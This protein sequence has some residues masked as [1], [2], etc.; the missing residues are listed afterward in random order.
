MLRR[1]ALV[2]LVTLGTVVTLGASAFA[3]SAP[4]AL[5]PGFKPVR[6]APPRALITIVAAPSAHRAASMGTPAAPVPS[7]SRSV[8]VKAT[9][10][11][12]ALSV[13]PIAVAP[14]GGALQP[15][16]SGSG[17]TG[18]IGSGFAATP[19][20]TRALLYGGGDVFNNGAALG[21]TWVWNGTTWSPKCG[22]TMP[23]ATVP[24]AP[25]PRDLVS[26]ATGPTGVVLYGG[27]TN[28]GTG[29]TT[30]HGDSY[31]W[32]GTA[33]RQICSS[34]APGARAG[35]AMAGNGMI[36]LL[37]GGGDTAGNGPAVPFG[38]TWRF[39]GN[40]WTELSPGGAGQPAGRL[41][42]SMAWDGH[43]FALFG[44]L[45]PNGS[46]TQ[47]TLADTWIWTGAQWVQACGQPLA[48]CG[49]PPRILG[50]F[51]PLASPNPA[52]E[53]ALL[54]G[55]LDLKNG[56]NA[57]PDVLGDI[58]SWNGTAWSKQASP[59]PDATTVTNS[60]P[61]GLPLLGALAGLPATCQV[62][63]TGDTLTDNG[64]GPTATA[65]TWNIGFDANGDHTPDPCPITAEPTTPAVPAVP[66]VFS[67]PGAHARTLAATGSDIRRDTLAGTGLLLTGITLI[68][69]TRRRHTRTCPRAR[70]RTSR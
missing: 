32:N 70:L 59:W 56:G 33:W 57:P 34:C 39:D 67:V 38:D 52:L 58:W 27:Q 28:D 29:N 61:G 40:T 37:F 44:G 69:A 47:T 10:K 11:A 30:L 22:T 23:G 50:G 16:P 8:K 49:P 48:G 25:G 45:I 65:G 43:H 35:A 12:T 66:V 54:V 7:T 36:V 63:L 3:A 9:V 60:F 19:D 17:P 18:R 4:S 21:D 41:G 2:A 14:A 15:P 20:G 42:A 46:N 26:A 31:E 51:A 68:T 1:I 55:G 64:N 13:P 6:V 5:A 62:A 53:G 24:C